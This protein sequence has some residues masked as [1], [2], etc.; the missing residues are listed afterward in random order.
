MGALRVFRT[1]ILFCL[2]TGLVI[3]PACGQQ[4]PP[5]S[6]TPQPFPAL[7]GPYFG[8]VPPGMTPELFAPEV[9]QSV[10]RGVHSV[11]Q[12]S[13]D[14]LEVFWGPM[15]SAGSLRYMKS[16]NGIWTKP[17]VPAFS[18]EFDD[19][20]TFSP[21]GKRLYF[22][23]GVA[24]G[25][26]GIWYVEKANEGWSTRVALTGALTSLELHW[27]LSIA[28]NGDLYFGART[29]AEPENK[30]DI[31]C[32][33]EVD[34]KYVEFSKLEGTINTDL[35]EHSPYIA[36]DGSYILFSRVNAAL[37]NSDLFVSFRKGNGTWGQAIE[38][39]APINT[40]KHDQCP[41]VS[42]DGKYLFFVSYR[43]GGA[44]VYWVDAKVIEHL[45][46]G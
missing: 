6:G 24:N 38:F 37:D 26:K 2:V 36:R 35:M 31:Y 9:F 20:P 4:V 12:F 22:V 29:S 1:W 40:R 44:L 17:A 3:C 15:G 19:S 41:W 21:D 8:Q 23:G 42:D 46:P 27:Q 45:R 16:E 34:G 32:S 14:G 30:Q 18:R 28:S 39:P 11:C 25:G 5:G 13:P 43:D 33:T 10:S 7:K